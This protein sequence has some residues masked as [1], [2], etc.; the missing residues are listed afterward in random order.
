[1]RTQKVCPVVWRARDRGREIL[2]FRHPLAGVQLVKGTLEAGEPVEDGALRELLEE[3][4]CVG[5]V[6]SVGGWS[7]AD[8]AEG[9]IWHFVPVE[10]PP[11][12]DTFSFFTRDDGGH[13]FQFFWWDLQRA[14]DQDW[15]PVFIRALGEIN[16]HFGVT[17]NA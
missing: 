10:T 15:H 13:L 8:V 5:R 14:A 11:L 17:R 4:G 1:M 16:Q 6:V 2:V 3:S 7:S 9:Q 12:P